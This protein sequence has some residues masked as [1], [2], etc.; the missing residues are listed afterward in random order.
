MTKAAPVIPFSLLFCL[1]LFTT[2]YTFR[3]LAVLSFTGHYPH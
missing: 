3:I 2:G 1:M